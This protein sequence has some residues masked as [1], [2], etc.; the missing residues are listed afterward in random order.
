MITDVSLLGGPLQN[1]A[2]YDS[3]H[4][5]RYRTQVLQ[6]PLKTLQ[7][8]NIKI[9]WKNGEKNSLERTNNQ[10]HFEGFASTFQTHSWTGKGG[11]EIQGDKL[12]HDQDSNLESIK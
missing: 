1:F 3:E 2:A 5:T 11:V 4:A 6:I 7:K 12:M 9:G 10:F 8:A